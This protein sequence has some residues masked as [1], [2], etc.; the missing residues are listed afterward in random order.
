MNSSASDSTLLPSFDPSHKAASLQGGSH[1]WPGRLHG[2]RTVATQQVSR[3]WLRV[4]FSG[5]RA[6][7]LPE[8]SHIART[9]R[10]RA[11]AVASL[12]A[13]PSHPL[14]A[15]RRQALGGPGFRN[16]SL[17]RTSLHHSLLATAARWYALSVQ[18]LASVLDEP[19]GPD[20]SPPSYSPTP[21]ELR[22]RATLRAATVQSLSGGLRPFGAPQAC[23]SRHRFSPLELPLP[24]R[25]C[26]RNR[27]ERQPRFP[28]PW[29]RSP[30]ASMPSSPN[31]QALARPAQWS[32]PARVAVP[33][34]EIGSLS[35][36]ARANTN[37]GAPLHAAPALL[38]ACGFRSPFPV[39]SRRRGS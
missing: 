1:S 2:A 6:L 29:R 11:P 14:R 30:V 8:F 3:S 10:T 26:A 34:S 22:Q 31:P 36:L 21:H 38:D 18:S 28:T 32:R 15:W 16:G 9:K 24:A 25:A 19:A 20:A 12:T 7:D 27:Y 5:R 23:R 39:E 33:L 4:G 37:T 35:T 13:L 17:T